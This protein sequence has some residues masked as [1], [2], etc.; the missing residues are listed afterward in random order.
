MAEKALIN[1]SICKGCKQ[2][3][4]T[5][6]VSRD[7]NVYLAKDCPRCGKSEFLV[8]TD[9]ERYQFKREMCGYKGEA[10]S[11][12]L[13][14]CL[15]CN[16]D[17][18]PSL[19]FI[20]VTN[21]CNM[22]CPICLANI[23]AMGFRFD[24][25]MEYFEKIFKVL[26][27]MNPRPKI[28]L[29]G[30][31][32]TV[33]EDLIDIIKL[34]RSYG[35]PSRV[36][37][38][39]IRLANEEYCKKLVET[40]AQLMFAFDGRHESIY[41]TIRKSTRSLGLKLKALENLRKYHKS[42]VTIMCAAGYGVND[43]YIGDLVQFCHDNRSFISALDMI[44]LTAHWGPEEVDA[45]SSTTE[46]VERMVATALPGT[47][48]FPAGILY[49]FQT[50]KD[51]FDVRLTFGGAHPNCE[52]VSLLI[53]DGEKYRPFSEYLK[54]DQDKAVM[55]AVRL[56]AEMGERLKKSLIAKLFGRSGKKL[57]Y[58]WT[59]LKTLKRDVN[60]KEVF[61]NS[62][63]SKTMK[64]LWGLLTG[65][66][67]KNL[68]RKHTRCQGILRLMVLPFEDEECVESA[69]LKECP[70]SFAYEHPE[71]KEIQ[72]MPVC[73][74]PI[75]KNGILRETARVYGVSGSSAD[76]SDDSLKEQ[77]ASN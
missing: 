43:Q 49:K 64:I 65:N 29:F 24:P 46:D 15:H 3:V 52:S 69:R 73:A 77:V 25:P 58:G 12:C 59:I 28:Q 26:H 2:M 53:S 48:F 55:D 63:G 10:E 61:G 40:R 33:R 39:G 68:I 62:A 1:Y 67:L 4:P 11:T 31:E 66:K 32:P 16:H 27:T 42:K 21:R 5:T 18:P 34:A 7:G 22:N 72:F 19:V 57:V 54:I 38:N 75:Y 6:H 74:W 44:P 70:A 51:V 71:T 17:K 47:K 50:L 45:H 23:P 9:A 14:N 8:S 36:V 37:T 13:M 35:I 30:G 41:Q 60:L 76:K 20:D 56:D